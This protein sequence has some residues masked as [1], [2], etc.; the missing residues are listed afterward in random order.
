MAASPIRRFSQP[1]VTAT[2]ATARLELGLFALVLGVC[3]LALRVDFGYDGQMMY[4]V[5]ESL[6]LRHSL[7]VQ[8]PVWHSNEPYA[9]FGLGVSLLLLPFFGLGSMIGGDRSRFIVLYGPL[10]T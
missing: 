5:T 10:V 3:L 7:Q 1:A 4:R 2:I 8:D 6:A 9:Y